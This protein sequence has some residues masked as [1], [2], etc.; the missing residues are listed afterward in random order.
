[1]E[2]FSAHMPPRTSP[3]WLRRQGRG[4]TAPLVRVERRSTFGWLPP[5]PDE[6]R[7]RYLGVGLSLF[8]S[9]GSFIRNIVSIWN[10]DPV[11]GAEGE[12]AADGPVMDHGVD[13]DQPDPDH[14]EFAEFLSDLGATAGEPDADSRQALQAGRIAALE[15][16]LQQLRPLGDMLAASDR[17]LLA[18]QARVQEL[19][20]ELT[21]RGADC[22]LGAEEGAATLVSKLRKERQKLRRKLARREK[23]IEGGKMRLAAMRDKRDER[24]QI[25]A[26]RWREIL[27]LRKANK[28]LAAQLAAQVKSEA[29]PEWR[30]AKEPGTCAERGEGLSLAQVMR[31]DSED[32]GHGPLSQA[33]GQSTDVT[34]SRCDSP[35]G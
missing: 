14:S 4:R 33:D 12:P 8:D 5:R 31:P 15:E 34:D 27:K 24:H 7:V 23:V 17:A 22:E 3:S 30:T 18:E 32:G 21:A 11:K 29:E 25:A 2:R 13:A 28:A 19:E 35:A 26:D 10:T 1:M 6:D 20:A 9:T 16:Q